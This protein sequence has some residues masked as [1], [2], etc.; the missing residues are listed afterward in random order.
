MSEQEIRA[1]IAL[2]VL[3]CVESGNVASWNAETMCQS[4]LDFVL[5]DRA[6]EKT[7]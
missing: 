2:A 3:R 5:D 1:Q 4:V 6:K 7:A